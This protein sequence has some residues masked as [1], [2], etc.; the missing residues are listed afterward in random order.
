MPCIK[1]KHFVE[2]TLRVLI[3]LSS[4]TVM[5][6]MIFYQTFPMQNISLSSIVQKAVLLKKQK[7]E[8]CGLIILNS[9]LNSHI[10]YSPDLSINQVI[11]V[12]IRLPCKSKNKVASRAPF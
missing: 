11:L 8:K 6:D 9:G 12:K 10:C 5:V 4:L 3:K 1:S 2:L 7:Q